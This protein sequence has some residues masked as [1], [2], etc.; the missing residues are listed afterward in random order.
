ERPPH[1]WHRSFPCLSVRTASGSVSFP[2]RSRRR[3]SSPSSLK[4]PRCEASE[5][6]TK[7]TI[8]AKTAEHAEK[9]RSAGL[10]SSALNGASPSPQPSALSPDSALS[11]VFV[12][13]RQRRHRRLR[14]N[15]WLLRMEVGRLLERVREREHLA[16]RES[17]TRDHQPDRKALRREAARHGDRRD[18]VGVERARVL[19]L[20][21]AWNV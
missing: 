16:L 20:R 15:R 9:D 18:A 19:E 8:N 21:V 17:R 7:T 5:T 14:A 1:L 11:L 13:R 12:S 6:A 2:A 4:A 10:A 3:R